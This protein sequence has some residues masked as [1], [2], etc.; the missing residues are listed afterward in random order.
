MKAIRIIPP[1]YF[2]LAIVT[3]VLLHFIMPGATVLT[4]PWSFLGVIPLAL[5]IILN[6]VAD[7]SFKK[8]KTPVKPLEESTALITNGVFRMTRHPMYL[9]FVLILLGLAMLMGSLTPYVVVLVFAVF[10]DIVF[11]RFEEK[12]LEETFGETW[13][14]YKARARRWL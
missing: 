2:F 1:N 12:K 8:H 13:L 4:I 3:M 14:D 11:M 10:M 5:G 6:L 9:G 7:G